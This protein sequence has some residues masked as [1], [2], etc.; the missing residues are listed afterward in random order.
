MM[1]NAEFYQGKFKLLSDDGITL[2]QAAGE[3]ML[4]RKD[5]L[6]V[7]WRSAQSHQARNALIGLA[8]GTG[9]GLGIGLAANHFIWSS[10]SCTESPECA[11]PPES[12][13]GDHSYA[14]RCSG[15]RRDRRSNIE[16]MDGGLPRSMMARDW[17]K[18]PG[19]F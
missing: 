5:I 6:R 15:R 17:H 18:R 12:A 2:R 11:P 1:N 14:C 13:L 4:A 7:S 16:G 8:V 3:Q 19:D 10:R 9:T